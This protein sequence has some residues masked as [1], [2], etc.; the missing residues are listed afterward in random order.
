MTNIETELII[1]SRKVF[2]KFI[3]ERTDTN[4]NKIIEFLSALPIFSS[5]SKSE[6][7]QL[8][9]KVL[10]RKYMSNSVLIKQNEEPNNIFILHSGEVR[11]IRNVKFSTNASEEILK[12]VRDPTKDVLERKQYKVIPLELDILKPGDIFCD[13]EVLNGVIMQTSYVAIIP[14]EVYILGQFDYTKVI[15]ATVLD[16]MTRM[17]T[18]RRYPCDQDLRAFYF[19]SQQWEGFK[20]RV[21]NSTIVGHVMNKK[22]NNGNSL[23]VRGSMPRFQ[24]FSLHEVVADKDSNV[25]AF[26][27]IL[28]VIKDEEGDDREKYHVPK[29]RYKKKLQEIIDANLSDVNISRKLPILEQH[30]RHVSSMHIK[31]N[32]TAKHLKYKSSLVDKN[33][34]PGGQSF[35]SPSP[36]QV[37]LNETTP[38]PSHTLRRPYSL[39]YF[40]PLKRDNN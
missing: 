25:Q 31:A 19:K 29:A 17:N 38:P 4:V 26:K 1:L 9:G 28:E 33:P 27:S 15:P 37:Q 10:V 2:Q 12:D 23:L 22:Y 18:A 24:P 6:L 14:T 16:S 5:L 35:M 3:K 36:D 30:E 34:I 39:S 7:A 20:S 21:L 13:N 32:K 8:G 11:A 40:T